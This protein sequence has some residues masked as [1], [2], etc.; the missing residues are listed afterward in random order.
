VEIIRRGWRVVTDPPVRFR[1][2]KGMLPLPRPVTGGTL[3]DLRTFVNVA[4]DAENSPSTDWVLVM[5]WLIATFK[6]KKLFENPRLPVL[7]AVSGN[8]K[9]NRRRKIGG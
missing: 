5:A 7:R 2:A 8:R 4:A 9:A 6:P 1:R 3:S